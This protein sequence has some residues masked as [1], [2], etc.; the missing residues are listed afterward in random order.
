MERFIAFGLVEFHAVVGEDYDVLSHE[1]VDEV[2]C[3]PGGKV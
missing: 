3:E 2:E 1:K